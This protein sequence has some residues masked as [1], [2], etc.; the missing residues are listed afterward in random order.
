MIDKR[1]ERV[2]EETRNFMDLWVKFYDLMMFARKGETIGPREEQEFLLVKSDI[3]RR[4]RA[5]ITALG[6]LSA[7]DEGMMNIVSQATSLDSIRSLSDIA[8]KKLENEWHRAYI[9][10]NQ[11]L[12]M[13]ENKREEL[14]NTSAFSAA[15][16]NFK[17]NVLGN[18]LAVVVLIVVVLV[19][20][21]FLLPESVKES[22]RE[23]WQSY[24]DMIR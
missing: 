9:S 16:A 23:L 6:G 19:G 8:M 10:I 22:L 24:M 1:L 18:K 21:Y 15:M 2:I 5:L 12:G 14:A 3:A 13:L 20:V 7:M 17:K 4:H 11:T